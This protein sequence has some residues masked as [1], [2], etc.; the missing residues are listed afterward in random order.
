MAVALDATADRAQLAAA[1]K[2]AAQRLKCDAASPCL[3]QPG[4]ER[5]SRVVAGRADGERK[6]R[7]EIERVETDFTLDVLF[8]TKGQRDASAQLRAGYRAAEVIEGQLVGG[9]RRARGQADILRKRIR[10][11]EIEQ[12]GEI[13]AANG[14]VDVGP[15]LRR[16]RFGSTLR[17]GIESGSRHF[18]LQP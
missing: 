15:G 10:R 3:Q 2:R 9:Q 7:R 18:G 5:L 1:G 12:R 11:L 17:V 16:P 6:R 13:D 4:T 8:V 14:E